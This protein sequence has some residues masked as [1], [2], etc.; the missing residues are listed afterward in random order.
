MIADPELLREV[1]LAAARAGVDA[2]CGINTLSMKI[3]DG[4]GQPAL[5]ENRLSAGLC[6]GPIREA[7]LYF[8]HHARKIIEKEQ[9]GLTL[10]GTGGVTLPDHFDQFLNGGADIAMSAV[11]MMWDPYLAARREN[12][13]E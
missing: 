1:L 8:V 2:V 5:G 7:A 13:V 6:G 4:D 3:V 10:M 12:Y 11:G 9:L